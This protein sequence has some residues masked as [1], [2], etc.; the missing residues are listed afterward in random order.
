VAALLAMFVLLPASGAR[1][2]QQPAAAASAI[3][4]VRAERIP[5]HTITIDGRLSETAWASAMP[6]QDFVQQQ[7]AEGRPST[8][9]S[10]VRFLYDDTYLYIGARLEE[11][12][13]HRLVVN[14]LRR[15]FNPRDGDLFVVILDTFNDKLNAYNFQTNPGCA[16]RDSQSHDDGR[17]INPNWDA[18]WLCRSWRDDGAWYVEEAIPF[19][20]LRFPA[21]DHQTWGLQIFRLVRHNNEQAV[22]SAVPRQFNQFKIS[23]EGVLD[24]ISGVRPGRNIRVKPF[25]IGEAQAAN[26]VRRGATDGGFDVKVGLGTNLVLDGTYRTDFSQV[27]ADAQQLNFTRFN[28][29]FPEKREFF[30]ENQGAFQMGPPASSTSNLVPFFSRTIGLSPTGMPVPIVGGARLTGKV[31]RN[32]LAVLNI[33]TEHQT[34]VSAANFAVAKYGREFGANS[35][36]GFFYLGKEQPGAANRI[37][38][39]D[40]RWYP[41][42]RTSIDGMFLR[43]HKLGAL[44]HAWR[45]GAQY[46]SGRT[47]YVASLTSLSSRFKD[48]LGFIP[49]EGVNILSGTVMRRL[50][51]EALAPAVRDIRPQLSYSRYG[52][53]R[54]AAS[55]NGRAPGLESETTTASVTSEFAD[56]STIDVNVELN[57]EVLALAFRPQGIPAG[58]AI[59]PGRYEFRAGTLAYTGSNGRRLSFAG[60][61]RFGEYYS[62]RRDGVT[63]GGRLRINERVASTVSVAR[64]TVALPEGIS[65]HT[66]LASVRLDASFSTRMF[67]NGFAQYNNVT[68]QISSNIRFDFIH[69]PLSDIYVVVN[70]TRF[71]DAERPV[72]AP[73][74]T[75]AVVVKMTHLFS[76]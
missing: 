32:N 76:F 14:E 74:A 63:A 69:H 62:G 25:L 37:G 6:A 68:R 2:D 1:A 56:A 12:E 13:P 23:Y 30:L 66:T 21:A 4:H 71:I 45:T 73:P 67:L 59:A 27:E 8:H 72:A 17:T 20:Q 43:S 54:S 18:A 16:L 9:A 26:A 41:T 38:G 70:D 33:Q 34:G 57:T 65:Y 58:Q 47:Q 40:L 29:F 61:W 35:S 52:R 19:K 22:W 3:R 44:G 42:R 75:R 7:P 49:R 24:G 11:D 5:A 55:L 15:D 31:G 28:L 50:R 46:D 51:P 48:D 39:A 36:L 64:D 53:S 60:V 10:D